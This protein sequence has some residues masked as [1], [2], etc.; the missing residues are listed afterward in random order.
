MRISVTVADAVV[1]PP[2]LAAVGF[3]EHVLYLPHPLSFFLIEHYQEL[4]D[5]IPK[6]ET[7]NP[8]P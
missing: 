1:L 2:E 6:P 3:A 5:L 7:L 4:A 8:R